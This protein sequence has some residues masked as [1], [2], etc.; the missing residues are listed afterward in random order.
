MLDGVTGSGK[1]EVYLAVIE[2]VLKNQGQILVLLPEIA[3]T[4]QWLNRFERRFGSKPMIWHSNISL[5]KKRQAWKQ[6]IEGHPSVVIGTRSA[7]F[8]RLKS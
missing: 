5:K 1:T 4:S 3:L 7:F 6:V 2:E 8:Y